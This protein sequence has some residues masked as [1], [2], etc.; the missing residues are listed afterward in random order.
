MKSSKVFNNISDKLKASIPKLKHG[1]SVVFQLTNGVP[2][3]EP[4]E[5]EKSKQPVLYP[6]VQ[7]ITNFRLFDPFKTNSSNEEVGGYV[8]V[9]C[10]DSWKG[11]EPI[12]FRCFI[13]GK[14]GNG[15]FMSMFPGKWELKGGNVADEELYEILYLSPQRVGT[16]CPDS[17][18][19]QIFKIVDA[20]EDAKKVSTKFDRLT[21]VIDIL[22]D[23]KPA[24]AREVLSAVNQPVYQDDSIALANIKDWAKS[25]VDDF[26]A[27][28]ESPETPIKA[29]IKEAMT[30]GKLDFNLSSGDVKI[31]KTV[32]TNMRLSAYDDFIPEFARWINTAEN[33]KQVLQNITSQLAVKAEV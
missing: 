28:Y 22:K 31:G 29:T 3:P 5:K 17:S 27:A 2:N 1:Q 14:N 18:V 9:G 11:D 21:K 6:K 15:S 25:N 32:I 13:P 19:E 12:A 33:G 24:K 4:D 20:M 16:P 26:L 30:A 7:L 8:D 10:V 23:I